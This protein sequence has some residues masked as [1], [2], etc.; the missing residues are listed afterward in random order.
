MLDSGL[1]RAALEALARELGAGD[2]VVSAATVEL[3]LVGGAGG[4]LAGRLAPHRVTSDCDVMVCVPEEAWPELERAAG[5]VAHRLG[6]SRR[7]LNRGPAGPYRDALPR[8]WEQRRSE[9]LRTGPLVIFVPG[10]VDFIA[11]KALANRAQDIEDLI[12]L[13]TT[14][15]ER[16]FVRHHLLHWPHDHWLNS[17]LREALATLDELEDDT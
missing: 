7:W 12:A 16:A 6:L 15:D 5:R 4:L 10:R 8:G 9:V 2:S 3:L 13:N 1:I 14:A 11:M 17:Q